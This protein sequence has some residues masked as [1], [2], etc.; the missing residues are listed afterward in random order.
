MR[1]RHPGGA[2]REAEGDAGVLQRLGGML[3]DFAIGFRI[4]PGTTGTVPAPTGPRIPG[5]GTANA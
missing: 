2:G 4:M 1:T 3:T 5:A